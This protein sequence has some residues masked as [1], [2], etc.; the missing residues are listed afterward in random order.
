M[1]QIRISELPTASGILT[2][3]EV[4]PAVQSGVDYQV[5]ITQAK[6]AMGIYGG[7]GSPTASA[8]DGSIYLRNDGA[9]ATTLYTRAQGVWSALGGGSVAPTQYLWSANMAG[10][11]AGGLLGAQAQFD[12]GWDPVVIDWASAASVKPAFIRFNFTRAQSEPSTGV[13]DFSYY[14]AAISKMSTHSIQHTMTLFYGGLD[15]DFDNIGFAAWAVA[16][17]KW[18]QS[19]FPGTLAAIEIWNE[20]DGSWPV[21]AADYLLMT[22]AIATAKRA[23]STL[24]HIPLCGPV[25]AYANTSYLTGL[26]Q[27]G[28]LTTDVDIMSYHHYTSTG[29]EAIIAALSSLRALWGSSKPVY[30]SEWGNV[31]TTGLVT[32][33]L[34]LGKANNVFAQSYFPLR[35]YGAFTGGM[36]TEISG[37]PRTAATAMVEWKTQIGESASYV[38][39]DSGLSNVTHSYL[40]HKPDGTYIRHIWATIPQTITINGSGTVTATSTPFYYTGT[41]TLVN[42]GDIILADTTQFSP[43]QD[44]P[45][46]YMERGLEDTGE[47]LMTYSVSQDRYLGS[48]SFENILNEQMHPGST[49]KPYFRYS[50]S[51]TTSV[52]ITGSFYVASG[53]DGT[54]IR[55]KT[56]L[57]GSNTAVYSRTSSPTDTTMSVSFVV[58]PGRNIDF[59]CD[60]NANAN[61]DATNFSFQI[62]SH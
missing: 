20:G 26:I 51:A 9:T 42:I 22:N 45:F 1:S 31:E 14:S 4:F 5:S 12:E 25:M 47:T 36:L 3:T 6:N 44:N 30:I 39:R 34:T 7:T 60:P 62:Y 32:R 17:A 43:V 24:Q 35:D 18:E 27:R 46:R 53:G 52:R 29:P 58:L 55:I 23:E 38:A 59:E 56:G 48:E 37:S 57:S 33:R 16:G 2:G 19:N 40:F 21:P 11:W 15:W 50:L 28:Y 41:A 61:F 49:H 10:T 13:Y 8:A 54:I